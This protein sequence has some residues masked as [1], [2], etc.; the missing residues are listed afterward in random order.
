MLHGV[1][2]INQSLQI[3]SW[4]YT[5]NKDNFQNKISTTDDLSFAGMRN[6]GYPQGYWNLQ[7]PCLIDFTAARFLSGIFQ[8]RIKHTCAPDCTFPV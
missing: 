1:H 5:E 3:N 7:L 8:V 2:K 6:E 4:K